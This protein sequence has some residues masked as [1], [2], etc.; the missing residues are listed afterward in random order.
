M[1]GLWE[2][3]LFLLIL[4]FCALCEVLAGGLWG[5]LRNREK[6]DRRALELLIGII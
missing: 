3:L 4:G 1:E 5:R 2:L 6:R